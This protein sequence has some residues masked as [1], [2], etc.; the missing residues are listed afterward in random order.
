[1]DNQTLVLGALAALVAAFLLYVV[2]SAP[3]APMLP[4]TE[5]PAAVEESTETGT[6]DKDTNTI[7]RENLGAR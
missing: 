4:T 3:E 5:A 2:T 1:M 7:I 6:P